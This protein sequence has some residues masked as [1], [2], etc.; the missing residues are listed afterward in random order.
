MNHLLNNSERERLKPAID[1]LIR[2]CPEMMSRKIP[3][4]NVQQG[5]V[6]D[7]IRELVKAS[8]SYV[9]DVKMLSVG[10]FEDT[11]YEGLKKI[12][13]DI[14]GIDPAVNC[15][16]TTFFEKSNPE[17][18]DFIIS[19]SVIEHVPNDEQ[20]IDQIC[21]LLKKGG[22]AVLTCDFKD[23]WKKG[24]PMPG[25]DQR[26]YTNYDLMV[27]LND[28]LINNQCTMIGKVDYTGEPDFDYC[29]HKYSF[30]SYVFKKL[31]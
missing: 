19:T 10:C 23:S 20:F 4:A 8:A 5:F 17:S 30:A 7:T 27:R 9:T 26:L 25:E 21:K 28:I 2:L 22:F 6:F 14:I 16:L 3:E 13:Y 18:F 12:G 31:Y 15:D 11:A 29:G 1:E 24:D